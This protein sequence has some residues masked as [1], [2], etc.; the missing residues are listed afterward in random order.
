M[1]NGLH[2][3]R[4]PSWSARYC[5]APSCHCR[6]TRQP[7]MSRHLQR[8]IESLNNELLNISSM[9]EEMIDKATQALTE[10]R[11]DLADEV[12]NSDEYVDQHEVHVEEECLKMLALHQPVAVDL[13]RIATVMKVNNDLERIADLAV[14][15]AQ[16]AQAMDEFPAFPIP[17]ELPRMVVLSTQMVRGSMDAFVNMD[18]VAARRII[19]MDRTV[20]QLNREIIAELQTVMQ[21]RPELVPAAVHCFSAVRHIERIADHATNI[22]EDVIYLVEGDIV[23]HRHGAEPAA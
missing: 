3:I 19:A 17:D 13:R 18:N 7:P 1:M 9:V 11:Y 6:P 16:R 21:Q 8:D 15:I 10:R 22:A 23:R 14:S 5:T 4:G 12:V 2:R 20:D